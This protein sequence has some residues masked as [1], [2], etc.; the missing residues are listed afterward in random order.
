L[1]G[2]T[3]VLVAM[4]LTEINLPK[5]LSRKRRGHFKKA[6]QLFNA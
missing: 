5:A 3:R 2:A 1:H 4:Q 6:P